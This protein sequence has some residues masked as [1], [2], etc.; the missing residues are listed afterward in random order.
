MD[1]HLNEDDLLQLLFQAEEYEDALDA[2]HPEDEVKPD[3]TKLKTLR[4]TFSKLAIVVGHTERNPGAKGISPISNYEYFW[5]KRLAKL[6]QSFANSNDIECGIF[7][8]DGVG[9]VGAYKK[10]V[11][12]SP[13][14]CVELHFNAYNGAVTGTETLY[15]LYDPSREWAQNIQNLMVELYER[16]GKLNRGIKKRA[17]GERGGKNV[18]QLENIPSCL[19]EPYFGDAS[20][21]AFLA[22][23]YLNELAKSIVTAHKNSFG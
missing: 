16:S 20:K 15:G 2:L 11:Q 7:F 3:L 14:S 10:V 5:N 21:D 1:E 9:I 18:N 22:D 12:W 23:N 19:I 4:F 17:I 8:R 6:I 13:H